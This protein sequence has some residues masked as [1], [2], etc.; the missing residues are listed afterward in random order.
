MNTTASYIE[1][2]LNTVNVDGS[3]PSKY[4]II[5]HSF[6][7]STTLE[8]LSQKEFVLSSIESATHNT[9]NKVESPVG[10]SH[11]LCTWG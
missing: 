8:S 2:Y 3:Q 4:L 7:S 5:M 10:H 1:W 11:H 6:I 9:V